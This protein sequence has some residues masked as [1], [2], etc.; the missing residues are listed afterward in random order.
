MV[1]VVKYLPANTGD[2]NDVGST[3]G[4]GRTPGKGNGNPL[5]YYCLENPMDRGAWC[6]T[7][8]ASQG[9]GQTEAA[10][11]TQNIN[12]SVTLATF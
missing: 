5:Q 6:T 9:V 10:E 12:T 4:S 11:H 3:P 7:L 8:M 1:L 2:V